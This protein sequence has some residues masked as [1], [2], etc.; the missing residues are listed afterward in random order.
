MSLRI[1]TYN[2][3][4][5]L[6]LDRRRSVGRIASVIERLNPDVVTLQEVDVGRARSG[7]VHQAEALAAHLGMEAFFHA[8]LRLGEER[9]GLATLSR[10]PLAVV[11]AAALPEMT[12]FEPRAALW[13]EIDWHGRGVQVINTHLGLRRAERSAQL[14]VLLDEDWAGHERFAAGG[15]LCGDFNFTRGS[16]PYR[17]VTKVLAESRPPRRRGPGFSTWLGL[18]T[19]DYIFTSD[20]F[21]T[22]KAG[23]GAWPR[24]RIASD[25]L[26]LYADILLTETT[27]ETS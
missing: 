9:Y 11:R 4:A 20:G 5:C 24:A 10:F 8:A 2:T 22:K 27:E 26:P 23:V 6:G 16:A 7:Y 13:T 3:H 18:R 19:L 21:H 1:L 12:P 14:A 17:R 25:H 15:V